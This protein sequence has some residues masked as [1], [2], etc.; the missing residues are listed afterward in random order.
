M[1]KGCNLSQQVRQYFRKGLTLVQAADR[2]G[3][4]EARRVRT[5]SSDSRDRVAN[6]IS[7]AALRLLTSAPET[8]SEAWAAGLFSS[9]GAV[10][11]NYMVHKRSLL[12]THWS[13]WEISRTPADLF[14]QSHF[15]SE[16]RVHVTDNCS[17]LPQPRQWQAAVRTQAK[18]C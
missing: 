1:Y 12:A 16:L 13:Y 14:T 2:A 10:T 15:H 11:F 3:W 17:P 8:F 4:E 18:P 9:T 6:L 5:L 7:A